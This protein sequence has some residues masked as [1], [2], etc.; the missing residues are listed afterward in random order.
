MP[1]INVDL[2]DSKVKQTQKRQLAKSLTK[3]LSE[4]LGYPDKEVTIIFKST[5]R[6]NIARAGKLGDNRSG[7]K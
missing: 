1:T 4:T 2:L 3:V 6:R 7:G 5:S